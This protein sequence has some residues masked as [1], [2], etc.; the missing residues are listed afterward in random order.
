MDHPHVGTA[1]LKSLLGKWF[2]KTD[3]PSAQTNKVWQDTC[4]YLYMPRLASSEVFLETIRDGLMSKEWFGYAAAEPS[5]Y[6]F[7]GLLLERIG[8]AYLDDRSVLIRAKRSDKALPKPPGLRAPTRGTCTRRWA[9][10]LRSDSRSLARRRGN[11]YGSGTVSTTPCCNAASL[12][13][14][15]DIDPSDPISSF[16]RIV[17]TSSS[18]S[19]QNTEPK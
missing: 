1:H 11:S 12:P 16:T 2:W 15:R 6:V 18:T 17:K 5:P 10:L 3:K 4:R 14:D 9:A 7:E 19:P 13:R 8:S